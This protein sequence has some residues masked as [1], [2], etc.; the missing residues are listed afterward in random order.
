MLEYKF[1][2]HA[3]QGGVDSEEGKALPTDPSSEE[4]LGFDVSRDRGPVYYS[5]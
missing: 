5:H 1:H 3:P 2:N 4:R